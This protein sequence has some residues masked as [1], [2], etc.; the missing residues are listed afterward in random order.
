MNL[1]TFLR[2]VSALFIFSLMGC[3]GATTA[4]TPDALLAQIPSLYTDGAKQAD[5]TF[6]GAVADSDFFVGLV[7]QGETVVAYLCNGSDVGD[8]LQGT[9]EGEQLALSNQGGTTLTALWQD[10]VVRGVVT[11]AGKQPLS[12]VATPAQEGITGFYRHTETV[13][14]A[15][16]VAGWVL[17]ENGIVGTSS[18]GSGVAILDRPIGKEEGGGGSAGSSSNG[19][20]TK[21]LEDR[22]EF[23]GTPGTASGEQSTILAA[24]TPTCETTRAGCGGNPVNCDA[25]RSQLVET[26]RA[27]GDLERALS[28][29]GVQN[30]RAHPATG[31]AQRAVAAQSS[32]LRSSGCG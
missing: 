26:E 16:V 13:N 5:S 10:G 28:Q 3:R 24:A 29:N 21:G 6:V 1:K 20:E 11:V 8:W 19:E 22:P 4:L 18:D 32:T 9:A 2:I 27:L 15:A 12:F 17:L 14:G 23:T 31:A 7:V 30:P 25:L